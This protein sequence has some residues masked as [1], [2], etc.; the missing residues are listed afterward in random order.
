[1]Q[2]ESGHKVLQRTFHLFFI[3][4]EVYSQSM[5]DKEKKSN[6]FLDFE[7]FSSAASTF[8]YSSTSSTRVS[9]FLPIALEILF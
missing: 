8:K 3:V 1:M 7:A 4:Q 6:H 9:S 5:R 2:D